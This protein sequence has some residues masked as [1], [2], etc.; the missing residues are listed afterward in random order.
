[1]YNNLNEILVSAGFGSSSETGGSGGEVDEGSYLPGGD[2]LMHPVTASSL[3]APVQ[4]PIFLEEPMDAY[5]IKGKP[6]VLTC[7][8]AHALTVYF[9]CNGDRIEDTMGPVVTD[10]VDPQTGVR[11]VEAIVNVTRNHVEEY[12]GKHNYQCQCV[13]WTSRGEIISRPA[14]VVV[15]CEYLLYNILYIKNCRKHITIYAL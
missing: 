7:R 1:M 2:T 14:N 3:D 9:R 6:A 5:V 11:N 13:A 12:F 8:A 10:F 15:A 4:L